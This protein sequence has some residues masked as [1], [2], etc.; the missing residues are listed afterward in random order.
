MA[1]DYKIAHLSCLC[2]SVTGA[3]VGV[4]GN[5][6]REYIIPSINTEATTYLTPLTGTTVTLAPGAGITVFN[7]AGALAA[8]TVK[9]PASPVDNQSAIFSFSQAITAL[10]V[11]PNT[12]Q[13]MGNGLPT[14]ATAGQGFRF[15]YKAAS[16]KWFRIF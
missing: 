11:S 1:S 12:G 2:D 14:A 7:P 5:D 13:T 6:G 3:F 15:I 9:M 4:V 10:T 16:L 8:L